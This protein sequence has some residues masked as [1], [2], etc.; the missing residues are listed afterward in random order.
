MRRPAKASFSTS[1]RLELRTGAAPAA[2]AAGAAAAVKQ[3][4][5][6]RGRPAKASFSSSF[7]LELHTGAAP[8]AAAAAIKQTVIEGGEGEGGSPQAQLDVVPEK[9]GARPSGWSCAQEPRLQQQWRVRKAG[10]K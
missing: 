8:A 10:S 1:F 3:E 2:A 5:S 9:N 6:K 4:G 7:R